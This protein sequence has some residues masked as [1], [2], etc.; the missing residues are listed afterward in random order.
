MD[1]KGPSSARHVVDT[2]THYY[3]AKILDGESTDKWNAFLQCR[4]ATY[5]GFPDIV[6]ADSGSVF[7]SRKWNKLVADAGVAIDITPVEISN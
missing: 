7:T 1:Q 4:V 2:D 3:A 5:V 6:K